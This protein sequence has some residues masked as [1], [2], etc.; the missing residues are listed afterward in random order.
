M[1]Q[2]AGIYLPDGEMHM[3]SYLEASG[4]EYQNRQ[5]RR[6]LEYVT[7][8]ELAL[9][10]GAHVGM[11]SKVLVERFQRV[12]AFEPMARLRACLERNVISDRID[13]IPIALGKKPGAVS[14]EY[15]ESHTGMTHV[16]KDRP[17]LIPVSRLDDFRLTSVG[18]IKIDTE[19]FEL[20]VLQGAR[21]TLLEN[22]PI[23]IV[24]EKFHGVRHYGHQPYAAIEY[25]E[26]LGAAVLDRI[27]DDFIMGWPD[28]PGKVRQAPTAPLQQELKSAVARHNSG[29]IRGAR[30]TYRQLL[31]THANEPELLHLAA[32]T[33]LQLKQ[34]EAALPLLERCASLKPAEGRFHNTL[35]TC[36]WMVGRHADALTAMQR[37][38]E[39]CPSFSE[40]HANLGEAQAALG[41]HQQA[42]SSL[43][44]ALELQPNSP[45]LNYKMGRLHAAH[46]SRHEASQLFRRALSL[47]PKLSAAQ[48]ALAQLG[49]L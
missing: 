45:N 8:W 3:P 39:A 42:M 16:S 27:V 37:A 24:E 40:A 2:V 44:R 26:S 7:N 38:V 15:D 12:V 10:I 46:G 36:L 25:L 28:T 17:G 6:S 9:D 21:A 22:K 47:D 19:G 20:D 32:I 14:F 23:I 33:E 5:L 1:K 49:H 35:G 43:A 4:G 30:L 31:R 48:E 13:V 34:P 18:Y 11:W 41:H 29:D